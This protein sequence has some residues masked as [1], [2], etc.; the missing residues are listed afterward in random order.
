MDRTF[1]VIQVNG[2]PHTR[3]ILFDLPFVSLS[4]RSE[5]RILGIRHTTSVK[6]LEYSLQWWFPFFSMV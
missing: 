6:I 4:R 2:E 5:T 3:R 1:S